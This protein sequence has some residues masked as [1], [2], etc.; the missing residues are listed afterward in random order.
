MKENYLKYYKDLK[1][2]VEKIEIAESAELDKLEAWIKCSVF[3]WN[4]IKE[5]TIITQ[6][7]NEEE[8]IIFFKSIKPA[9]T[10]KIEYYT[11]RYQAYLFYPD[12]DKFSN[13]NFWLL[14]I[15]RIAKFYNEQQEFFKYYL[16]D[17]TWSDYIY[18]LRRNNGCND[19]KQA[20]IYDFDEKM[21]TS[22]DWLIA[23]HIGYCQYQKFINDE[24]GNN[25]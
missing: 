13:D 1:C 3:H 7:E 23:K 14:E 16:A 15:K 4:R 9:F 12:A 5:R 17:E 2:A 19:L 10:G 21:S 22:H 8:E 25:R 18:F 11:Q 6:F 20:R 24:L